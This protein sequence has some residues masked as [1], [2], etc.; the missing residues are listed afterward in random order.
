[1]R[2]Y[3]ELIKN[4]NFRKYL[5]VQIISVFADALFKI[6]LTWQMITS[7][8]SLKPIAILIGITYIPQLLVGLF[9]SSLIDKYNRKTIM[10]ISDLVS[11]I[12]ILVLLLFEG[13]N[14]LP[15]SVV[16][17]VRF[18][19]STMD[20]FYSP[21][22]TA[23]ITRIVS[24]DNLVLANSLTSIL[25][26]GVVIISAGLSAV[27]I[28]LLSPPAVLFINALFYFFSAF[29]LNSIPVN[30]LVD[31][32]KKDVNDLGNIHYAIKYI[33]NH[34]YIYQFIILIFCSNI[35]FDLVYELPAAYSYFVLSGT[36][37]TY[38]LLQTC[39]SIGM[40]LGVAIVGITSLKKAGIAF[41]FSALLG[42]FVLFLLSSNNSIILAAT[43]F[44]AFSML[45]ALSTPCFTYL[46]LLVEDNVKGRVFALFDTIVLFSAPISALILY[47]FTDSSNVKNI[48]FITS[49]LLV[50]VGLLSLLFT[51][52][53]KSD[54]SIFFKDKEG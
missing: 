50:A 53:R 36:T 13:A 54:L 22:S 37:A 12:F 28:G 27:L 38:G 17:P 46:Q 2:K 10:F 18:V 32:S 7:T 9:G 16:F 45:D 40:I 21:A 43:L 29:L 44:L 11:G 41:M 15:F 39:M 23:Y 48:Y 25:R 24:A 52:V 33:F 20:V 6:S 26:Q 42:G 30:G 51:S 1:M 8:D 31:N 14:L 49:I 4:K 5:F 35:V 3:F 34:P 47:L 19:L